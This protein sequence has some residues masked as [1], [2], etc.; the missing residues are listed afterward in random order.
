[1][2]LFQG[3]FVGL[4]LVCE[5]AC[6]NH[7]APPVHEQPLTVKTKAGLVTGFINNTAPDVR[8]WL[9]IPYAEPPLGRLRFL[10]PKPKKHFGH[11]KAHT[12]APSCMQQL[13]NA[14]TVYTEFMPQ[15]LINGGQ[16]EDCLYINIYAPL[17]PVAK[18][19]PVFIYIPG[20]GFTGGGSDSLYKIPD[21]WIQRSQTHIV[22]IMNYRVNIFGFPNAAAQPLNAGLLDQ[23][24]VVEWVRDNIAAFGGS[25]KK[26]TLWGQSAGAS[27]VG[28]Y[29]YAYPKDPIV[30]GLIADSGAAGVAAGGSCT[31]FSTF[32]NSFGCGRREPKEQLA[33][34][35]RVDAKD[36]QQTLSF[37]NTGARFAPGADNVTAFAN[38]TERISKG[39]IANL[40]MITGSN[41]NEGAGF[42]TFNASGLSPGQYQTGLNAITCPVAREVSNR[43]K[44]GQVTYRYLYGGN[45]SNISPRPW[46]GATHSA[47][48]PLLFGTHYEYR[49]NSTAFEW[50]VA[51][52]M[53]A[54]WLSFAR[55]PSKRPTDGAFTWPKYQAESKTL[56]EFAIDD[57]AASLASRE[58]VDSE[59]GI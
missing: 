44:F 52:L 11:V 15:F 24:L 55:D 14:P 25:P 19:L 39:L 6:R 12:Y 10:P 1:M 54:L 35:Q 32:A 30:Q 8:Q 49:G 47:E 56:V 2:K 40:P 26:I 5:A 37:G 42:G 36:I 28:I 23:R 46:I 50:E 58:V 31:A 38:Y 18:D 43:D 51:D 53:Q 17:K 16:S 41:T 27:S 59:C 7:R 13:S 48:L 29:G 4:V 3:L 20:G 9:G 45:F 21:K 57:V 34:L 22:V 33:C